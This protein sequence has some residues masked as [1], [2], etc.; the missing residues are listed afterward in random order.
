MTQLLN[1]NKALQK[2]ENNFEEDS[3]KILLSAF[4][5][6]RGKKV[7]EEA[8]NKIINANLFIVVSVA[9]KYLNYGADLSDLI[10]EGNIG[11]IKAAEKFNYKN[12]YRFSTYAIYWIQ[13]AIVRTMYDQSQTIRLPVHAN[14]KINKIYLTNYYLE[15]KLCRKPT[16]AEIAEKLGWRT[17]LVTFYKNIQPKVISLET[18]LYEK[19]LELIQKKRYEAVDFEGICELKD[20]IKDEI[21]ETPEDFTIDEILKEQIDDVL[22][23]LPGRE[24]QVI[25]MRFGLD[26]GYS[27]TLEEVGKFFNNTRERIR[28]IEAKALR[29]LRHPRRRGQLEDYIDF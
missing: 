20:I 29:R 7:Y 10:Q 12:G 1:I 5:I 26:D 21:S 28:Q 13:Q 18:P 11:L 22:N 15:E 8:K 25:R 24:Q 16:D 6:S 27:L 23:T 19:F 17:N 3:S 4:N 2:I 9:K 14:E